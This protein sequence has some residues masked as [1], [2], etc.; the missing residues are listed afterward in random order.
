VPAEFRM[1]LKITEKEGVDYGNKFPSSDIFS[2]TTEYQKFIFRHTVS[3]PIDAVQ[4]KLLLG[5]TPATFFVDDC[6]AV[7]E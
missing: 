6:S 2:T 7:V 1:Q 4:F 3:N 5:E